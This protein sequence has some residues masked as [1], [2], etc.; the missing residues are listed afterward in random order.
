LTAAML[1]KAL[2]EGATMEGVE[3]RFAV[4]QDAWMKDCKLPDQWQTEE[5]ERL[6]NGP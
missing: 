2:L 3:L 5:K 4:F 6:R 1:E